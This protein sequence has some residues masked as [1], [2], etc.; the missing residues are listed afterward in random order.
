MMGFHSYKDEKTRTDDPEPALGCPQDSSNIEFSSVTNLPIADAGKLI[1][2][3]IPI[4]PFLFLYAGKTYQSQAPP[5]TSS[6]GTTH[7]TKLH[8]KKTK[9]KKQKTHHQQEWGPKIII[10]CQ[11]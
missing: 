2:N 10:R 3:K 9:N 6:S 7:N 8:T 11:V 5:H 1:G 4:S